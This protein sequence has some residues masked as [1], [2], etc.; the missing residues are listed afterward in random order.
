MKKIY[1]FISFAAAALFALASCEKVS[2]DSIFVTEYGAIVISD[3]MRTNPVS[4]T[5]GAFVFVAGED[6]VIPAKYEIVDK[7]L[8]ESELGFE[9]FF[10]DK[11]ASTENTV[12]LGKMPA[13]RYSGMLVITDKRD[14]TK[15]SKEFNFQVNAS[16]YED[17][18]AVLTDDGT[19]SHVNYITADPN[20]GE[21]IFVE[22]VLYGA[23]GITLPTGMTD[24]EY[25]MYNIFPQVFA[26]ALAGPD[27]ESCIEVQYNN[28]E[29]LGNFAK[30]F[31]GENDVV[32][33]NIEIFEDFV[34][35]S[36]KD[37]DF[38]L[39]EEGG[40]AWGRIPH[41]AFFPSRPMVIGGGLKVSHIA[42]FSPVGNAMT[43]MMLDQKTFAFDAL[44]GR[45][46]IVGADGAVPLDEFYYLDGSNSGNSGFDGTSYYEDISFPDPWDLGDYNVLWME[47]TGASI[48]F[49]CYAPIQSVVYFL[50]HKNTGAK[51]IYAFDYMCWVGITLDL[52]FPFPS[53]ISIDPATM[54]SC[55]MVGG[56]N[57]YVF[58]TANSNKDI[59]ALNALSGT[60]KKVYSAS[61]PV[62]GMVLGKIGDMMESWGGTPTL[63]DQTI[64]VGQEDGTILVLEMN[65]AV[66]S[67]A[68]PTVKAEFKSST[69]KMTMGVFNPA[70]SML[71]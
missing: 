17:G 4:Q 14:G 9:W 28:M 31:V 46:L 61:S 24:M 8:K 59:Y 42:S 69:G 60:L 37:G 3:D 57:N 16:A 7:S 71:S 12:N 56:N 41:A 49:E 15:Y 39:R 2:E 44:N 1:T 21:Y 50:E 27:K 55:R 18:W 5:L 48:D 68:E 33:S 66:I 20:T 62:T 22:D 11:V 65:D 13:G 47:G 70:S 26:V 51:Y 45:T 43:G 32:F 29:V 25:H 34:A 19:N 30:E 10:A 36:T 54:A 6:I 58:F 35:A 53:Q 38:F 23:S 67:G 40:V 52:F 63:Y 64:V